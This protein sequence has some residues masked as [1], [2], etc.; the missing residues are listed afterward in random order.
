LTRGWLEYWIQRGSP[1]PRLDGLA[2]GLP[3]QCVPSGSLDKAVSALDGLGIM[4]S[5]S[6]VLCRERV[7]GEPPRCA[8]ELNHMPTE[9][10]PVE[11][12]GARDEDEFVHS[13]IGSSRPVILTGVMEDWPA[14]RR[15]SL[16]W[17]ASE[18]GDR[19]ITVGETEGGHLVVSRSSG[20]VQ[21]EMMLGDFIDRLR[22]GD[23][24][25]YLLSSLDERLPELLDDLRF[26]TLVAKA[27]WRS[28]RMWIGGPDTRAAL[29][30]DLPENFL[31]Q[32]TGR[33]RIILIDRRHG[34]NVYRNGPLHG[35][36]NFCAVDAEDP[37]YA[38]FPRFRQVE[39]ITVDLEP[40]EILYIPRLW[41]H[42]VR[43]LDLSISVNQW[44]ASGPL[45][46][47]ARGSQ[48]FA[49]LRGL[50]H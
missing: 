10:K 18:F 39:S 48:L 24:G 28:L 1:K 15:W 42:Q 6:W 26:D 33:K 12:I 19:D 43:S 3:N 11:R 7:A 14:R 50:R 20:V 27:S 37:D 35:A 38:R 23:P 5:R 30:H 49:R 47:A 36:P 45:A 4:G 9:M 8:R 41:W 44:F 34:R 25:Y 22:A 16:D 29:H 2:S 40:G 21:R 31:A 17:L 13:Y 46:L 32:V